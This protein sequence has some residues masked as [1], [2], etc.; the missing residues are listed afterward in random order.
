MFLDISICI[1]KHINS[2][3]LLF[4]NRTV[5]TVWIA[6]HF[7]TNTSP[8]SFYCLCFILWVI[9][10]LHN[11]FF[12]WWYI[13]SPQLCVIINKVTDKV[14]IKSII[15]KYIIQW[16][17]VCLHCNATITAT[18]ETLCPL[19]S[20]SHGLPFPSP[21]DLPD[22]EI[23]PTSP[24]LTGICCTTEPPRKPH[25]GRGR[26]Q[27]RMTISKYGFSLVDDENTLK[28]DGGGSWTSLQMYKNHW[29]GHF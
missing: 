22:P 14:Y 24:A 13:S 23:R 26:G 17:L 28:P 21:G 7:T 29:I 1:C 27:W 12:S 20:R 9:L 11:L 16:L 5:S 8:N 15:L 4:S 10:N 25:Q 6:C 3:V 18:Q 2:V 19:R